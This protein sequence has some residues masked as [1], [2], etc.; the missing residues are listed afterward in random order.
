MSQIATLLTICRFRLQPKRNFTMTAALF[1]LHYV[2][3]SVDSRGFPA[4]IPLSTHPPAYLSKQ[5][6]IRIFFSPS[7]ARPKKTRRLGVGARKPAA[8][9][10]QSTLKDIANHVWT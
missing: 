5:R 8:R 10:A 2:W 7:A 4:T 1:A 3:L 9:V 6:V